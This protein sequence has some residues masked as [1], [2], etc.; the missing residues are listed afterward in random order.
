MRW[1]CQFTKTHKTK[2]L[3]GWFTGK[4]LKERLFTNLTAVCWKLNQWHSLKRHSFWIDCWKLNPPKIGGTGKGQ[5]TISISDVVQNCH[6]NWWDTVDHPSW[7]VIY[8]P[9]G[10]S[11]NRSV[12]CIT[13]LISIIVLLFTFAKK[14]FFSF[15][16]PPL[17]KIYHNCQ[18]L[19]HRLRDL[20]RVFWSW[21]EEKGENDEG[22]CWHQTC[23]CRLV[24]SSGASYRQE[25]PVALHQ[26]YSASCV[27]VPLVVNVLLFYHP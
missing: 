20:P 9:Q 25:Q 22:Y 18:I 12:G 24:L 6:H 27:H 16:S 4:L 21:V 13:S 1:R 15:F 11:A 3:F 8:V 2:L 19:L 5:S 26:S 23:Y 14:L 17:Q 10:V 7:W